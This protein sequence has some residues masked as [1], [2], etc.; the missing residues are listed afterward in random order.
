MAPNLPHSWVAGNTG[1]GS[2]DPRSR[3]ETPALDVRWISCVAQRPSGT[4][5][6]RLFPPRTERLQSVWAP[7]GCTSSP[8]SVGQHGPQRGP[9][10]GT[11][12]PAS[13]VLLATVKSYRPTLVSL[14]LPSRCRPCWSRCWMR[15]STY[16][17]WTSCTGDTEG[18]TRP[19]NGPNSAQKSR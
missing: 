19:R 11:I 16:T 17:T 2:R 8:C 6:L 14:L 13:T 7:A 18:L 5:S 15:W 3:L 10:I 9:T 4:V 1:V 12:S